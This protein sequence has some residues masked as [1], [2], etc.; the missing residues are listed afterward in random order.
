MTLALNLQRQPVYHALLASRLFGLENL[1]RRIWEQ[2][3]RSGTPVWA[4]TFAHRITAN[5]Y[6]QTRSSA[7]IIHAARSGIYC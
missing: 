3:Q 2:G 7:S 6:H 4:N 5:G 1:R